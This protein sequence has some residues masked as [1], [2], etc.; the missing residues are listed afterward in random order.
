MCMTTRRWRQVIW[1]GAIFATIALIV[2]MLDGDPG[3]GVDLIFAAI[4]F[5][6]MIGGYVGEFRAKRA[7]NL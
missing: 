3:W 7:A 6:V 5:V 1:A 2:G 4:G